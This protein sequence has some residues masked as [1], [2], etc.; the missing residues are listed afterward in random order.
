M[1][2]QKA[3]EEHAG[4]R[5][6]STPLNRRLPAAKPRGR[7]ERDRHHRPDDGASVEQGR[8]PSH[9][10]RLS[11]AAETP[12]AASIGR[13]IISASPAQR[14]SRALTSAAS[15]LKMRGPRLG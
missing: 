3:S 7:D 1:A 14:Q 2:E 9:G 5:R 15:H 10:P 11:R 12:A 13:G 6:G 8:E 4:D